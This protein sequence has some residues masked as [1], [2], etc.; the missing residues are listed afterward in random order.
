MG[1]SA[2]TSV[3][4]ANG[5]SILPPNIKVVSFEQPLNALV[6]MVVPLNFG[7]LI[8]TKL[9]QFLKV[10]DDED[11]VV[12][13]GKNNSVKF[14]PQKQERPAISVRFGKYTLAKLVAF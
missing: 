3:A 1:V 8:V 14:T 6:L 11:M 2:N 10:L 4:F 9:L 7:K 5:L 12:R 13:F